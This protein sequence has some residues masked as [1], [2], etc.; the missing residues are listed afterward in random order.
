M[1]PWEN[2]E[3]KGWLMDQGLG[4]KG[5]PEDGSSQPAHYDIRRS[6]AYH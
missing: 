4:V 6:L 1:P 5:I 3:S 2:L